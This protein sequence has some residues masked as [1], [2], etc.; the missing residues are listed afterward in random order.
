[1]PPRA[2]AAAIALKARRQHQADL[3]RYIH[4]F[5]LLTLVVAV[6]VCNR[7]MP[8][9]SVPASGATTNERSN[10]IPPTG[11][12]MQRSLK[13][14]RVPRPS[15]QTVSS[16]RRT[17][18][19]SGRLP[20]R[21][22][23]W[24]RSMPGEQGRRRIQHSRRRRSGWRRFHEVPRPAS[25]SRRHSRSERRSG[26]GSA[27]TLPFAALAVGQFLLDLPVEHGVLQGQAQ[28]DW[29]SLSGA[30]CR[31]LSGT[32]LIALHLHGA[33]DLIANHHQHGQDGGACRGS[34]YL[35]RWWS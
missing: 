9:V 23:V 4:E 19:E 31:R 14:V 22:R 33:D 10:T 29:Q 13:T 28:T 12:R 5:D 15:H 20:P 3:G 26:C 8:I 2:P 32:R 30:E 24:H 16:S 7:G 1:M 11:S 18:E 17:G 34:R 21:P 27:A 6:P 25:T 35:P